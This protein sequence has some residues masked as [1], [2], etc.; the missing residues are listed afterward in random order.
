MSDG[1]GGYIE[2]DEDG[3][4]LGEWHYDPDEGAWIYEPYV[5]LAEVPQT[6]M[7]ILAPYI[8]AAI[9]A[10]LVGTGAVVRLGAKKRYRTGK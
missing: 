7:A 4:P 2:V 1:N 5:P 3:V 6:G 8:F 10:L 9:G